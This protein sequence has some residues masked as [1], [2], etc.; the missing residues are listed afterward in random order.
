LLYIKANLEKKAASNPDGVNHAVEVDGQNVQQPTTAEQLAEEYQVDE[1]TIRR[2][3]E[4]ATAVNTLETEVRQEIRQAVLK[5][6][7]REDKRRVTKQQ[8]LTPGG[9]N[10][11]GEVD[12]QNDAEPTTVGVFNTNPLTVAGR[13][14][15]EPRMASSFDLGT[16]RA[17]LNFTFQEFL[18]GLRTAQSQ[19]QQSRQTL[20]RTLPVSLQV[21]P[22]P[23]TQYRRKGQ[24]TLLCWCAPQ[25]C[26]TDVVREA[27][28]ALA[29]R[30]RFADAP[31]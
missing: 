28:L 21:D 11:H 3:G 18:N 31:K 27:V 17:K 4:F 14:L 6:K 12:P 22:G 25:A 8:V 1:K 20:E 15:D 29:S 24:L 5:R 2:D 13:R 19:A 10:Q 7:S 16:L 23:A 30:G 26:H 9:V